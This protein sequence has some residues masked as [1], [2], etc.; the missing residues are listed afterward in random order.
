[1]GIYLLKEL[2]GLCQLLLYCLNNHK[3]QL[4][5]KQKSHLKP[6]TPAQ[7]DL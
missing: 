2:K 3:N 5:Q 1:M 6:K 4:T 7:S